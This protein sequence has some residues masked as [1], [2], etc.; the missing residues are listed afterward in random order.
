[1]KFDAHVAPAHFELN[2]YRRFR[3]E[4][5]NQ[6]EVIGFTAHE[7]DTFLRRMGLDTKDIAQINLDQPAAN[8]AQSIL[9]VVGAQDA[10]PQF[11][12]VFRRSLLKVHSRTNTPEAIAERINLA[13]EQFSQSLEIA[14]TLPIEQRLEVLEE[15]IKG[16]TSAKNRAG[17]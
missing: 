9:E 8:F 12:H 4:L 15:M 1:M 11:M 10:I 2:E 14:E 5:V 17:A 6:S 3:E 13:N 16:L 7:R